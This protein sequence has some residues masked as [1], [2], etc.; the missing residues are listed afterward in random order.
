MEARNEYLPPEMFHALI[1]QLS[2][3]NLIAV[4]NLWAKL[5]P[6]TSHTLFPLFSAAILKLNLYSAQFPSAPPLIEGFQ[7]TP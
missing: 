2:R 1:L 7:S 4:A 5:F 3:L 6:F